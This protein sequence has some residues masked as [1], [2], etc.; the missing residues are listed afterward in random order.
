MAYK[1]DGVDKD[2]VYLSYDKNSAF[3]NQLKKGTYS[4]WLKWKYGQGK[5][6]E[7]KVVLAIVQA[8]AFYETWLAYMV[9]FVLIVLAVYL[10]FHTYAQR[11]KIK[12]EV[13]LKEE[14]ARTKLNYFTNISHE[15]LTPLTVISCI[16]D[17]L[18]QKVPAI[19]QQSVILKSNADKLKRLIQQILDFRKMDVGK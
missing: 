2:W 10:S 15:L 11:I 4:F 16:T 13:K 1:L 18:E 5:W 14:L 8:P 7:G 17:H 12:N 6:T 9:Y 19:R 3:Y